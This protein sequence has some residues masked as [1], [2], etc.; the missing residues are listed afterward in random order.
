[1][2]AAAVSIGLTL[3]CRYSYGLAGSQEWGEGWGDRNVLLEENGSVQLNGDYATLFSRPS[4]QRKPKSYVRAK[5]AFDVDH[6][7]DKAYSERSSASSS[8]NA[9]WCAYF[10]RL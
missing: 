4:A 9:C 1:M 6:V 2:L 7:F 10:R 8:M 5:M 3:V